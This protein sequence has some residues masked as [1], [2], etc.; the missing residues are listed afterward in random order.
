MQ[1]RTR[2]RNGH[3]ASGLFAICLMTIWLAGCGRDEPP[4][5]S[6]DLSCERFR[7][8][9]ATDEQIKILAPFWAQLK[10]WLVQIAAHNDAYDSACVK[11]GDGRD[12]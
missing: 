5:V 11:Q 1:R 2:R 6:G 9:S 3:A 10:S 12:K 8:I 7:H 4:V